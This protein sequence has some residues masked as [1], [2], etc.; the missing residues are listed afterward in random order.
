MQEQVQID[1]GLFQFFAVFVGQIGLLLFYTAVPKKVTNAEKKGEEQMERQTLKAVK[2]LARKE[3]AIPPK[4]V[5]TDKKKYNRQLK[6]KTG[7]Q[8]DT[9]LFLFQFSLAMIA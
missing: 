2:A 5:H 3:L 6:H 1:V 8:N 9:G 7:Y 4:K